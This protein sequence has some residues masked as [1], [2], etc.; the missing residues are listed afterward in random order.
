MERELWQWGV[1]TLFTYFWYC[2][3]DFVGLIDSIRTERFKFQDSQKLKKL[4]LAN[5]WLILNLNQGHDFFERYAYYGMRTI[6]VIYLVNGFSANGS[7]VIRYPGPR[8]KPI[9]V[10]WWKLDNSLI[11]IIGR[12]SEKNGSWEFHK[13]FCYFEIFDYETFHNMNS[14][15]FILVVVTCQLDEFWPIYNHITVLTI[16]SEKF[17]WLQRWQI[18]WTLSC[19]CCPLLLFSIAWWNIIWFLLGKSQNCQYYGTYLSYRNGCTHRFCF[20]TGFVHFRF[21]SGIPVFPVSFDQNHFSLEDRSR[22]QLT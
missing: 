3:T 7:T 5:G 17:S 20:T 11:F 16:F 22:G 15:R 12:L 2:R 1:N 10:K 4:K 6:L 14:L 19:V 13:R 9:D 21:T 18:D 8:T